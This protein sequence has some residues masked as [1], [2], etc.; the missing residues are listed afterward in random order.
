MGKGNYDEIG[1]NQDS[2]D[3]AK[4]TLGFIIAQV[5]G[6]IMVILGGSWM[7]SYHKGFGWDIST[8]FN[9]HPLFMSIGMIYL[10]GDGKWITLIYDVFFSHINLS[11]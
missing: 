3:L 7:G 10:Y 9:Y 5:V 4:F 6:L 11:N 1:G 8:V 2:R